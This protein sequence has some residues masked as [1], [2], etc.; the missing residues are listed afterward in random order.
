ML[1]T[2]TSLFPNPAHGRFTVLLPPV[3]GQH[4]VQATLLNA[5]GQVVNERTV[6]L[7][8]AGATAEYDTTDLAQGVYTLRL[9]AGSETATLKVVID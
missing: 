9:R 2:Q 6:A 8:A 1:A 7:Q 3:A 5:L 4:M